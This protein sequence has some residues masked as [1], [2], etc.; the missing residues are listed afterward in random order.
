MDCNLPG[1]SVHGILQAR[2]LEWV[3]LAFSRE[4]SQPRDRTQFPTLQAYALTSTLNKASCQFQGKCVCVCVCVSVCL[5]VHIEREISAEKKL[6]RVP[7]TWVPC[8]FTF[9]L[10]WVCP[11]CYGRRNIHLKVMREMKALL[12]GHRTT[13]VTQSDVKGEAVLFPEGK[14]ANLH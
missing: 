11:W 10:S 1:S 3:A 5:C 12:P 13:L 9:G 2:I 4:S 7:S 6:F 14:Q 8:D